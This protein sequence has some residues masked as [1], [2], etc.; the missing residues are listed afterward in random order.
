MEW[1]AKN[2]S[3]K[4]GAARAAEAVEKIVSAVEQNGMGPAMAVAQVLAPIVD[5]EFRRHCRIVRGAGGRLSV[6]VDAL[7]LVDVMRRKWSDPIREGLKE[8]DR[9]MC[10]GPLVFELGQSGVAIPPV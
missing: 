9:R 5:D 7:P 10:G 6:Q 2:R 8:V 4:S 1:V 3:R